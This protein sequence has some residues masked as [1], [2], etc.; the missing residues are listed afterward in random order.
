[1][2][3][4][5]FYDENQGRNFPI[6]AGLV[7]VSTNTPNPGSLCYLPNSI[8]IDFGSTFGLDSG[9]VEGLDS[10]YLESVT[11]ISATI[12][13]LFR[14][15]A[16]GLTNY[17]LQFICDVSAPKYSV[18]Y[19]GASLIS[20]SPPAGC[21]DQ[22]IWQGF[23][24]VGDLTPLTTLLP[25]NDD[26]LTGGSTYLLEPALSRSLVQSYARSA[27]LANDDRTRSQNAAGCRPPC[28]PFSAEDTYIVAQCLQGHLR[29]KA[30]YN[31]TVAVDPNNNAITIAA[32]LGAGEGQ[33]CAEVPV[34]PGEAPATGSLLLSGGP[35]CNQTIRS[36]NGIGGPQLEIAAGNGVS[37]TPLTE[38]NTIIVN[39]NFNSAT[40]CQ[41]VTGPSEDCDD[42]PGYSDDPCQ[43]GP[44]IL[45]ST[46]WTEDEQDLLTEDDQELTLECGDVPDDPL[47]TE[48]A[49]DIFTEDSQQI[50]VET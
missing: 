20:G 3:R 6:Q 32:R 13:F 9:Y 12:Q 19:V 43:C 11:R 40:T 28:L 26:V 47:W 2:A 41:D 4:D 35:T 39:V 18:Q 31:T 33:P 29:F 7:G 44:T 24:V 42:V 22:P 27:N 16:A 46:L 48:D 8:L 50:L 1:M 25:E 34:F 5:G 21:A 15:T 45:C 23:L 36:I 37:V 30:G 49:Q 10:V 38:S 14:T 17:Q